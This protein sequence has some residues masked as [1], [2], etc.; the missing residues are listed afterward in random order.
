MG[1]LISCCARGLS[2]DTESTQIHLRNRQRQIAQCQK[3]Q[4][5]ERQSTGRID[6]VKD[7]PVLTQANRKAS[8]TQ[9]AVLKDKREGFQKSKSDERNRSSIMGGADG[10]G[11]NKRP[12]LVKSKSVAYDGYE[13]KGPRYK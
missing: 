6:N 4:A 11:K 8:L 7:K 3:Q 13:D 9:G 2:G 12:K 1:M 5:A 10:D